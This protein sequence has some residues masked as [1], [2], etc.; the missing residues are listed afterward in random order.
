MTDASVRASAE[1]RY[2]DHGSFQALAQPSGDGH[3]V[4]ALQ[5]AMAGEWKLGLAVR[6]AMEAGEIVLDLDD[7]D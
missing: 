5:F 4:A 6:T 7:Y 3:Y 2:M 1:M